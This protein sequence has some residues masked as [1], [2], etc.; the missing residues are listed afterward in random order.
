MLVLVHEDP[1]LGVPAL[2]IAIGLREGMTLDHLRAHLDN[3]ESEFKK[4]L[5]SVL[6]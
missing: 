6:A 3:A 5:R 4:K 1:T 2:G